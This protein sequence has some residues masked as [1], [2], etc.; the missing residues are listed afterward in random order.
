MFKIL[1]L[2]VA[3]LPTACFGQISMEA[4]YQPHTP[5]VVGCGCAVP[6]GWEISVKWRSSADVVSVG[7]QAYVWAKPGTHTIEMRARLLER[8]TIIDKDG[9]EHN[10]IKNIDDVFD[11]RT[12]M[13]KGTP[14]PKPEP[15]PEPGPMP[16]GF[17]G[18]IKRAM[19]LVTSE[20]QIVGEIA[21]NYIG[22]AGQAAGTPNQWDPS[23]MMS[24][25]RTRNAS[26]MTAAQAKAWQP[27]FGAVGQALK[28]ENLGA[29]DL[30][31]HIQRFHSIAAGMQ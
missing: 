4:E 26:V 19:A 11:E 12:F 9:V 29:K 28:E 20:K 27:F 18:K 3:L 8:I 16:A 23:L 10:L 30:P 21:N 22:V 6:E 7:T 25:V 5:I 24:E 1:S 17:E 15:E 31:G 14:D 13:V 2:L